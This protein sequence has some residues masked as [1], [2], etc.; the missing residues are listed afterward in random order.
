M[1]NKSITQQAA[2]DESTSDPILSKAI[3]TLDVVI[4][5]FLESS[6]DQSDQA[7]TQEQMRAAWTVIKSRLDLPTINSAWTVLTE[8]PGTIGVLYDPHELANLLE[9]V[10]HDNTAD[11]DA[12][13]AWCEQESD[14]LRDAMCNVIYSNLPGRSDIDEAL[15]KQLLE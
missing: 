1:T 7:S 4:T 14:Y 3:K 11:M 10:D 2:T 5:G 9:Y 12:L 13:T 8:E 6:A 15:A